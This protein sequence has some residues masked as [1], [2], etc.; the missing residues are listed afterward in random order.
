MALQQA[1]WARKAVTYDADHSPRDEHGRAAAWLG[2]TM[3]FHNWTSLLEVGAGTG[4]ILE[5]IERNTEA[6]L[7]VLEHLKKRRDSKSA[8]GAPS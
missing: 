4:R 8:A 7:K 5:E 6:T 2:A 1:H 3:V